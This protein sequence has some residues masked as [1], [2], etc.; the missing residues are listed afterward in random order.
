MIPLRTESHGSLILRMGGRAGIDRIPLAKTSGCDVLKKA[1]S[2]GVLNM[3][4]RVGIEPAIV[5]SG[6]K[7]LIWHYSKPAQ[8]C[9]NAKF[10]YSRVHGI[11][12][13]ADRIERLQGSCSEIGKCRRLRR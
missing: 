12:S 8:N 3:A 4:E 11:G 7:L 2:T 1:E 10:R 6:R 5:L 13:T 9:R